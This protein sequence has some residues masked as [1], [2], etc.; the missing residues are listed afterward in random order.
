VAHW[1]YLLVLAAC[2]IIT[3]PLELGLRTRVYARWQRLLL[4]LTPVMIMFGGWDLYAVSR[5]QWSYDRAR[6]LVVLPGR[7]PLEEWLF[8]VVI[9]ICI[10]L[11]FEA[12]R[13]V[14]PNWRDPEA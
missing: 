7:L 12:V 14:R 4:T 13:R 2:L 1:G 11:S 10:I 5:H 6:V 3:L 9:P 8:F